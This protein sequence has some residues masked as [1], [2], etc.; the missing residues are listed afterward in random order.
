LSSLL[1]TTLDETLACLPAAG[2]NELSALIDPAWIE[3]ALTAT[4][5]ASIRRRKLPADHAVWLVIGLALFRHMRLWQVVQEMALTLDGQDLP[6]PSSSQLSG[7]QRVIVQRALSDPAATGVLEGALPDLP[8]CPHCQ[9]PSTQL[10]PCGWSRGLRRYRCR[11][12]RRTCN[13]LTGTALAR[14][15]KADEWQTYAESLI[16]G[17]TIRQAAEHCGIHK[18]T[19]FL[20]RHRFLSASK[21]AKPSF[22]RLSRDNAA[23]P[24]LLA[25]AA[26]LAA[27]VARGRNRSR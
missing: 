21:R 13:P 1:Q 12:C 26:V 3:Q 16:E 25:D 5:K 15:R 22:W 17:L 8:A 23:C 18:N 24:G 7:R 11:A 4:G 20:W 2:V 27:R 14:L 9:A 6:V 10:A 19:A